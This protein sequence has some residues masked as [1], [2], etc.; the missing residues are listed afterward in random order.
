MDTKQTQ[1]TP[2]IFE[3][4]RSLNG[5]GFGEN[6]AP[7]SDRAVIDALLTANRAMLNC[8][9]WQDVAGVCDYCAAILPQKPFKR[10]VRICTK[11]TCADCAATMTQDTDHDQET[12]CLEIAR[13]VAVMDG[14][15]IPDVERAVTHRLPP[16]SVERKARAASQSLRR[17]TASHSVPAWMP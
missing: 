8:L 12:V 3:I 16:S 9:V 15:A 10:V 6:R 11:H 17:R 2:G 4:S 5:F 1:H 14:V 13:H 7:M